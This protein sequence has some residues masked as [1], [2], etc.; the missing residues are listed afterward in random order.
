MSL[1][2]VPYSGTR[3]VTLIVALATL[4]SNIL[5]AVFFYQL[6][7]D[8][9]H[10]AGNF[11]WYLHVANLLSVFGFIGALRQH[12]P[13]VAIF[14]NYLLLDTLLSSI[15]RFF[16]LLTI[17]SFS[18]SICAPFSALNPSSLPSS[19]NSILYALT[20]HHAPHSE[21]LT[22]SEF[23]PE[24]CTQTVFLGQLML[25]AGVVA[26]TVLQLAGALCVRGYARVL[27][28][29]EVRDEECA[30]EAERMAE[31]MRREERR[32]EEEDDEMGKV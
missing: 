10:L 27:W 1:K 5:S 6:P 8:P 26:A 23:T 29:R 15:P 31:E 4:T 7:E 32:A 9:Y 18:S 12:A 20:P 25:G 2:M 28:V 21:Y 14:A 11:G 22:Q 24:S 16:I 30:A 3:T 17:T 13:S 19:S